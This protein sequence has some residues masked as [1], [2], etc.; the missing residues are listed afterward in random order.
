MRPL[1]LERCRTARTPAERTNW[2]LLR[3]H[4]EHWVRIAAALEARAAGD[5]ER[6]RLLW[7]RTLELL[8]RAEPE[9][10]HALD[11]F[12]YTR[13]MGKLFR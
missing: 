2:E 7:E 9:Y 13:V 8:R 10:H 5:T 3:F 4:G 11:L 1:I 12:I 6:A